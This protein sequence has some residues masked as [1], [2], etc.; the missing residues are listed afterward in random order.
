MQR[1]RGMRLY[2]R[3]IKDTIPSYEPIYRDAFKRDCDEI[4]DSVFRG[5]IPQRIRNDDG[6]MAM[7]VPCGAEN[8]N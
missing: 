4:L 1:V 2:V 5:V 3:I 8:T 6:A 7:L